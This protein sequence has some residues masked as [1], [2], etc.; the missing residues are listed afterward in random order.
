MEMALDGTMAMALG[1]TMAMA[2][3][4]TMEMALGGTMADGTADICLNLAGPRL[5][6]KLGR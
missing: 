2:L 4:G 3:G 1:G 5:T 6:C